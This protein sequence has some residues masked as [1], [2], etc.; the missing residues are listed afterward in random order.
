MQKT[1][2]FISDPG[3]GWVKVP[4]TMLADLLISQEITR[5]SYQRDAFAYL[6]EDLDATTFHQAYEKCFGFPPK[7]RE[8]NAG[9]KQSRVRGY[10]TYQA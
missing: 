8:R 4:K 9:Q 3:H 7:Y 1:F 5:Y 10:D 6:E 2:D